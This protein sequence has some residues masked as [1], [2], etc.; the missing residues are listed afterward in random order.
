MN[1]SELHR[2]EYGRILALVGVI[3]GVGAARP[4]RNDL[5]WSASKELF[6]KERA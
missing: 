1:L 3:A 4:A 2:R 5:Q 6:Q